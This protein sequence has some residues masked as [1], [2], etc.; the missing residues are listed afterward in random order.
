MSGVTVPGAVQNPPRPDVPPGGWEAY[1]AFLLDALPALSARAIHPPVP[2]PVPR[3]VELR[4]RVL[5]ETL[6]LTAR[7]RPVGVG[8]EFG[9]FRGHSLRLAARRLPEYQFYGF[10]SFQ[11]FP[12]D[13]RH[14]WQVEFPQ[15]GLPE[16]PD[17]VTLVPGFYE[18]TLP[19]FLREFD[20]PLSLLLVDCDLYSSTRTV[21][22]NLAEA[23]HLRPGLVIYADELVNYRTALW[24]E[25]L[26]LFEVLQ[27][28]DLGVEWLCCWQHV[29]SLE[30]ILHLL[31]NATY[32]EGNEERR[33]G[34]SHEVALRLVSR[35]PGTGRGCYG[36][37]DRRVA[38]CAR[39]LETLTAAYLA[40][41]ITY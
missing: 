20:E 31:A 39:Q 34:Y 28:Y 26:A 41:D 27:S 24:N 22:R 11:G 1:A 21:L 17:R 12:E 7:N 16:V 15:E 10:D 40:G 25:M 18:D 32:P 5:E 33:A 13:G 23:G 3:P 38:A 29:R 35:P 37:I 2:D 9:V 19:A 6:D 4:H 8:M 36:H 30:E 14:D